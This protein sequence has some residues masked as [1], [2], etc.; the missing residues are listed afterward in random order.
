MASR[1]GLPMRM[2]A[3]AVLAVCSLGCDA[4]VGTDC[5]TGISPAI[6]VEIVD[7]ESGL[8]AAAEARGTVQDGT[9]SDSLTAYASRAD[10]TLISRQ[11]AIGRPGE[12]L[13]E[14]S[15]PGYA[16]WA[17]GPVRVLK[18]GCTVQTVT[19]QAELEPLP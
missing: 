3:A 7:A 15:H 14:I 18:G 16:S 10:G 17:A 11:A 2:M 5:H 12:Y 8:P 4:L 1:I 9:Y 13:V 19:M 6:V